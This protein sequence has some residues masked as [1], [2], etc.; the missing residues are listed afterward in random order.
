MASRGKSRKVAPGPRK[1]PPVIR[2]TPEE[3]RPDAAQPEFCA[4]MRLPIVEVIDD[5]GIPVVAWEIDVITPS[6]QV[7]IEKFARAG[8][9]RWSLAEAK[10]ATPWTFTP[11]SLGPRPGYPVPEE[12]MREIYRQVAPP[13][14]QEARFRLGLDPEGASGPAI[15]KWWTQRLAGDRG[16]DVAREIRRGRRAHRLLLAAFPRRLRHRRPF[17]ATQLEQA[18]ASAP[19][20]AGETVG[21]AWDELQRAVLRLVEFSRLYLTSNFALFAVRFA[22][23]TEFGEAFLPRL[24]EAIVKKGEDAR[25]DHVNAERWELCFRVVGALDRYEA[26]GVPY[27][28]VRKVLVKAIVNFE[29]LRHGRRVVSEASARKWLDRNGW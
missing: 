17:H 9:G 15:R 23:Q 19:L 26:R 3:T 12:L 22:A 10:R 8:V 20:P 5:R 28:R 11:Q 1:S 18:R 21:H 25:R 16:L 29:F 14:L 7:E 24:S 27:H 13:Q 2:R 6:E 4:R